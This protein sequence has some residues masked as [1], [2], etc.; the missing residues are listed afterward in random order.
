VRRH[1]VTTLQND[2][3]IVGF[4]GQ[5]EA[6][7]QLIV[8]LFTVLM[9]D[10]PG[11]RGRVTTAVVTTAIGGAVAHPFIADL[12][13]DTLRAELLHVTRRLIQLPD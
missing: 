5:H 8:R 11:P 9:G 3:V 2:P 12:D 4:L 13:E 7:Q 10:D 6:F 1:A